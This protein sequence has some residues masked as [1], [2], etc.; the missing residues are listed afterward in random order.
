MINFMS[1][2]LLQKKFFVFSTTVVY[3]NLFQDLILV[4]L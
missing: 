3:L 2:N 4:N 1:Q